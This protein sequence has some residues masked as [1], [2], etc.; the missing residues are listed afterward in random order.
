MKKMK[1]FA[2]LLLA[3]VM[4][5]AMGT[6]AFAGSGSITVTNPSV[7]V[8][9]EAYKI[10]DVTPS[11]GTNTD[12]SYKGV[13]YTIASKW[14]NYFNSTPGSKYIVDTKPDGKEYPQILV[15]GATK[16]IGVDESNVSDF[17][18][19]AFA[20]SQKQPISPDDT[21]SNGNFSGLDLGY[22]MVYPKG[23][24]INDGE[25]TTIVS[26]TTTNPT[27]E[28][29]QKAKLPVIDKVDD[30]ASVELGQIVNYTV[31]GT[32][33]NT[34]GYTTFDYTIIDKMTDGLTFNK[35][36]IKVFIDGTEINENFTKNTTADNEKTFS[37]TIDVKKYQ[38]K[39]GKEI[40]ITYNATV[41]SN[42]IS[43]VSKN[44][45]ILQYSNDPKDTSKK[46]TTPAIEETV[47]SAKLNVTK[48]DGEDQTK[49]LAG[50]KFVLKC[51]EV[52]ET[53]S[54]E[55]HKATKP[56][57]DAG[58]YYSLSSDNKVSWI[59]ITD[60]TK[61]NDI[62]EGAIKTSDENGS[63][64]FE[65]LENGTYELYEVKAPDGYNRKDGVLATIEIEGND[66]TDLTDLS[67]S[68]TI[69]NNTGSLLPST[70]GIGTTIFYVL[71]G[72]LVI[73][74]AILL[75]TKR[76]MNAKN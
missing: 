41:N 69:E 23:A 39:V 75:V 20:Y 17:A 62:P 11:T 73:A 19:D 10:F 63:L 51:K 33:P 32:V 1:K 48:V 67:Y 14:I 7:G 64:S 54:T 65:G 49:K 71:G 16:Y 43:V 22:Y 28:I 3:L 40:K 59:E 25:Y 4:V 45:A 66:D 29:V 56:T 57:A 15:N 76:R 47:Y 35:D 30:D 8:T 2:G 68:S 46:G 74:A 61:L 12:G 5:L 70:G 72:I 42:A 21:S 44:H 36:S 38:D 24:S 58:K 52:A 27:Q 13:T 53:T 26:L 60:L 34:L 9:F 18:K 37:V 55:G 50:A 31:T 6:T